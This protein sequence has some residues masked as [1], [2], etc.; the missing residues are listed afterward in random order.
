MLVTQKRFLFTTCLDNSPR[1]LCVAV[2][3]GSLTFNVVVEVN[4]LRN[5]SLSH[6]HVLTLAA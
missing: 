5:L 6:R 3:S 1:G 2:V 4:Q